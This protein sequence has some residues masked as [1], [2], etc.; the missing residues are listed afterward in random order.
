[1]P[2]IVYSEHALSDLERIVEFLRG[3]D[4]QKARATA[5]L[6]RD[7]LTILQRHPLIGRVVDA[8]YR[9][10]V[11]SQGRTGFI[12]LYEYHE[13]HDRILVS[14]IRHQREAGFEAF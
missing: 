6:I 5:S 9:E 12:A 11:I 7:A 10:L 1:L 4:P 14:A 8:R 2:L 13:A 3:S